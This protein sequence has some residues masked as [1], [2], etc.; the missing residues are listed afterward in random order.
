VPEDSPIVEFG[1]FR[2]APHR[3]QLIADGRPIESASGR[4]TF[5]RRWSRPAGLSSAG[6][7]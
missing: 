1:R 4:L 3:R 6:T 2:I 7:R 5:W